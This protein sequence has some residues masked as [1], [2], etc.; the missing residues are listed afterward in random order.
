MLEH[1]WNIESMFVALV[2]VKE[3]MLR[4]LSFS[5]PENVEEKSVTRP[6]EKLS[7]FKDSK[8]PQL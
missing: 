1:D 2:V 4:E 8:D 7:I 5:H 6:V 3:D